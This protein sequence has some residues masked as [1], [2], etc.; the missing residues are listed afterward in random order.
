MTSRARDLPLCSSSSS[1][2]FPRG[3]LWGSARWGWAT[4]DSEEPEGATLPGGPT[5]RVAPSACRRAKRD[6]STFR[7]ARPSR[8][9]SR[10]RDV[11]GER[12]RHRPPRGALAGSDRFAQSRRHLPTRRRLARARSSSPSSSS[13]R[14]QLWGSARWGWA[15]SASEEPEGATLPGGPT[16]RVAPSACRRAKRD[17][18]TF[19]STGPS[20]QQS[21]HRARDVPGERLRHRP[22]RRA[23]C[24]LGPLRPKP[25]SFANPAP[26]RAREVFC[27]SSSSL[28]PGGN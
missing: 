23:L 16:G 6:L 18:S 24:R 14:G 15:T 12:L 2:S 5:G 3:Q 4:S 22:P 1:S 13:P 28:P 9:Q 11:P 26:P 7:P 19:R 25:A 10:A 20:R 27:S 17:L 21:S 8:R